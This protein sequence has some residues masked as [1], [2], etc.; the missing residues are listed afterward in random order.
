MMAA[1]QVKKFSTGLLIKIKVT[2]KITSIYICT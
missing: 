1:N 2:H